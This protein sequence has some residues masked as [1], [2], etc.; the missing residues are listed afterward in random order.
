MTTSTDREAAIQAALRRKRAD[1]CRRSRLRAAGLLE[2]I[3]RCSRC[4]TRCFTDRWLPLCS[5]CAR[6]LGHDGGHSRLRARQHRQP[7]E[8]VLLADQVLAEL[9]AEARA[10]AAVTKC[11]STPAP[12]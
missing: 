2:P 4:D 10:E 6:R 12:G 3:P 9:R 7:R 11:D 8:L 1:A 5:V